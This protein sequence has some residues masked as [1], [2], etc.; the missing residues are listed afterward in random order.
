MAFSGPS[1]LA[2]YGTQEV[3]PVDDLTS[4]PS[5][6]ANYLQVTTTEATNQG[7]TYDLG[8]DDGTTPGQLLIIENLGP[9]SISFDGDNIELSTRS[10]TLAVDGAM[11]L[12]WSGSKWVQVALANN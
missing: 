2:Q 4:L 3:G 12:I 6:I 10:S 7:D 1:E 5:S 8:L 9:Q 11:V